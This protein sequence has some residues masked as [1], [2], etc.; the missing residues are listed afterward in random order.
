MVVLRFLLDGKVMRW[1]NFYIYNTHE[2][3]VLTDM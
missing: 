3:C 1:V 2:T